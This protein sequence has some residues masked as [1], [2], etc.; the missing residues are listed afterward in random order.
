[1]SAVSFTGSS[2]PKY[3]KSTNANDPSPRRKLLWKPKSAS[4][5]APPFLGQ[6]G[7]KIKARGIR[8][9]TRLCALAD[10]RRLEGIYQENQ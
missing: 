5:K 3:S 8:F 9:S 2:Q 6:V 4:D 10:K 7:C 1:M